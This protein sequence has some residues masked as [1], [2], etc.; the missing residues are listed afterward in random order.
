MVGKVDEG[1]ST[2][3][4]FRTDYD[5]EL[6]RMLEYDSIY[7]VID[8]DPTNRFE[9]K[10]NSLIKNFQSNGW[11]DEH[12]GKILKTFNSV[13]PRIYGLRK[14]HKEGLKLRPVVSCI[15]AP[16]YKIGVYLHRLLAPLMDTFEFNVKNSMEFVEFANGVQ[17]PAG[18]VLISL[19]VVSLF[20]NIQQNLVIELVEEN[21]TEI[22]GVL[23]CEKRFL[24]DLIECSFDTSFFVFKKKVYLQVDGTSMGCPSS[25]A[26]AN[27]VMSYI[28]KRILNK[29][30][31]PVPFLKLYVDDTL[32]AVPETEVDRVLSFFNKEQHKI[33]FTM[34]REVEGKIAFL[35]VLVLRSDDGFLR[36]SWFSKTTNSGRLL[37]FLSNHHTLQKISVA[38]GLIN[39][40]VNLSHPEFRQINVKKAKN[41]L[42]NNNYPPSFVKVCLERLN[43]RQRSNIGHARKDSS[44]RFYYFRFPFIRGLSINISRCF[45]GTEW[46]AYCNLRVIGSLYTKLKDR[47][48][49]LQRSELVYRVPCCCQKT[50][51]GQTK[52]WLGKRLKQHEYDC[53]AVNILKINKIALAQHHFD[54]GHIF[55]FGKVK[56]LDM[57]CCGKKTELE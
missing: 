27:L 20:T 34:E 14:V 50:Y 12:Q 30:P 23:K 2:V 21:W 9:N 45:Y 49:V 32:L 11:L 8:K 5:E 7:R 47:V 52:Q 54:T 53:R 42:N 17:L 51:V 31:F 57:E 10:I 29:L 36:T 33:Q 48:D 18:F 6:G 24:L 39:R 40:A 56:I 4:M 44:R 25:S 26:L 1:G 35:D 41:I 28:L 15:K 43:R 13:A 46:P 16:G 19:D 22:S 55:D 3:I 37:N 38:M